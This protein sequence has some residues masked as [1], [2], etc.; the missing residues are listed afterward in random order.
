MPGT[1]GT[2]GVELAQVWAF[3]RS[4]AGHWGRC[5]LGAGYTHSRILKVRALGFNSFCLS[6]ELESIR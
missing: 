1:E 4:Y 5:R 6:L 2:G 3:L